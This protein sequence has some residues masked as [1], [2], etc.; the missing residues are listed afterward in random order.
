MSGPI[1]LVGAG[2]FTPSME[3]LDRDLLAATGVTRP[4][5]VILPTASSPDGEAV[6]RRWMAMGTQH[7]GRL[8]ADV[9]G[10]PVHGPGDVDRPEHLEALGR[11]DLIYLSGGKPG[12]LVTTLQG[13]GLWAAAGAAHARGARLVGCSAGAMALAR[14]QIRVRRWTP[15]PPRWD[16][17]LGLA[18]GLAVLPHYDQ[19]PEPFAALIA[20]RAPRGTAI[21]GIDEDT[22]VVGRA[23]TWQ[24]RGLRR[25][26]VWRGRHR[27]RLHDGDVFR[28]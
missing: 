15:F 17:A 26:T 2:E 19:F 8:G 10:L 12:H 22:A 21:L 9:E 5:V 1:V 4:R 23:G 13:S 24:V 3:A 6:F 16:E 18:D 20:F 27:R 14:Y 28:I 25:V 7:F 11:A